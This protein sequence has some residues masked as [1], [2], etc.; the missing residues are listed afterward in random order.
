MRIIIN[1]VPKAGTH[2]A[3]SVLSEMG[4]TKRDDVG[5]T[6]IQR[7]RS[8]KDAALDFIW[9]RKVNLD[10]DESSKSTSTL[11]CVPQL[12]LIENNEF[13]VEHLPYSKALEQTLM[14]HNVRLICIIRDPRAV[15]WSWYH[16]MLKH[17]D[18]QFHEEMNDPS[19]SLEQKLMIPILGRRKS[20][21]I[22]LASLA[23][24][25]RRF[26]PWKNSSIALWI[27]FEHLI[28]P[29]GGGDVE[30]QQETVA[31]IAAFLGVEIDSYT[32]ATAIFGR[33]AW[34]FRAGRIDEWQ[35]A[36][37]ASIIKYVDN[38]FSELYSDIGYAPAN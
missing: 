13:A 24:R 4:L 10:L 25:Y 35:S 15:L 7:R 2:L 27:K 34:T 37:P 18:Y 31:K 28:G 19:L 26:L 32:I 14:R 17:A 9:P 6:G 38:E 20:S 30:L 22:V 5:L 8:I 12:E 23:D 1:S 29:H 21:D 33:N 36:I 16:H 3:A 11:R